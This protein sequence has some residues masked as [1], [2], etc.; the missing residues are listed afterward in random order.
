MP[1]SNFYQ[2]IDQNTDNIIPIINNF[3]TSVEWKKY[4]TQN[5]IA[6]NVVGIENLVLSA[7]PILSDFKNQFG[8]HLAILKFPG[9]CMYNWHKDLNVGCSLN[10]VSK[11]YNCHTLFSPGT[12]IED[13][14]P[15]Y[16]YYNKDGSVAHTSYHL[17]ELVELKYQP[18]K[19]YIFNSQIRHSIINLDQDRVLISYLFPKST[20]YEEVKGWYNNYHAK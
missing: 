16:K 12:H 13:T 3:L 7:L 19:F 20:T 17:L 9:N 8:G 11:E 4:S 6:Q 14:G 10:L 18:K 2:I 1:T 15:G 5:Y